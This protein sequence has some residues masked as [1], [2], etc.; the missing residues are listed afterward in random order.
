MATP[1][2]RLPNRQNRGP[3]NLDADWAEARLGDSVCKAD[4]ARTD[5]HRRSDAVSQIFIDAA[6][7]KEGLAPLKSTHGIDRTFEVGSHV[8]L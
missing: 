3:P 4:L 5:E 7:N 1:A 6:T 2:R 8:E